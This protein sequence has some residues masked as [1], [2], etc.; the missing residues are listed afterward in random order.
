MYK[1]ELKERELRGYFDDFLTLEGE[2]SVVN[3][4]KLSNGKCYFTRSV[5]YYYPQC[6]DTTQCEVNCEPSF[7]CYSLSLLHWLSMSSYY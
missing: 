1:G 5:C 7:L 2:R 6:S 4:S 3:K